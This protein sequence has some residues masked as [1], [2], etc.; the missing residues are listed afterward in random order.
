V[1]EA[2]FK[3]DCYLDQAFLAGLITLRVVHGNGTGVLKAAVREALSAHPLVVGFRDGYIG[4]GDA[5]VT[6]MEMAERWSTQGPA[7]DSTRMS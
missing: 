6:V 5:G 4:E 2:L 1:A 7:R 3:L